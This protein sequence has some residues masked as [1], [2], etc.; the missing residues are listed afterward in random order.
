MECLNFF[1][2]PSL[3]CHRYASSSRNASCQ[4]ALARSTKWRRPEICERFARLSCHVSLCPG[5]E[6]RDEML[7]EGRYD[8]VLA[9]GCHARFESRF[10][11]FGR[12]GLDRRTGVCISCRSSMPFWL[13]LFFL[14]IILSRQDNTESKR[15]RQ[16]SLVG[17]RDTFSFIRSLISHSIDRQKLA[18]HSQDES[19]SLHLSH[20]SKATNQPTLTLHQNPPLPCTSPPQPPSSTSSSSPQ[21]YPSKWSSHPHSPSP[22]SNVAGLQAKQT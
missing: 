16:S 1:T 7:N 21:P 20:R 3:A 11:G 17:L 19:T 22:T 2:F 13:V 4:T 5:S 18:F 15:L 9:G 14:I 8:G 6:I 10:Y 12:D